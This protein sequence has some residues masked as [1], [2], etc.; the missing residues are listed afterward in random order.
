MSDTST[1]STSP[2]AVVGVGAIMP[3]APDA[4]AAC[5]VHR[6]AHGLVAQEI[7]SVSEHE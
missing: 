6:E 7:Y 3:D 5:T 2:I 4:D 1:R